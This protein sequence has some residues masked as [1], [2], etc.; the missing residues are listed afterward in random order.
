M[1]GQNLLVSISGKKNKLRVYHL[2]W[3]N[4]KIFKNEAVKR[5]GGEGRGLWLDGGEGFVGEVVSG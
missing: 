5:G 2:S 1:Q 3:L 4:N